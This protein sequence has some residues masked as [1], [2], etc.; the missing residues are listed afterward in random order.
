MTWTNA[1]ERVITIVALKVTN[2]CIYVSYNFYLWD[3]VRDV[4]CFLFGRLI[5]TTW[6]LKETK[7]TAFGWQLARLVIRDMLGFT[8]QIRS[9]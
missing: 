4:G 8:V 2:C 6:R 7:W 3:E 5:L 1:F 9:S